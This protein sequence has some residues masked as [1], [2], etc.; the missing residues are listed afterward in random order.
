MIGYVYK[1]T[2]P[3]GRVYIGSTKNINRRKYQYSVACCKS[4]CKL[5]LS[6]VK[7]GWNNHQFEIVWEG[8]WEQMYKKEREIG[9][10]LNVLNK[11]IG[12]N[13]KLPDDNGKPMLISPEVGEKIS[14]KMKGKYVGSKNHFFGKKH[15]EEFKIK[16][17][18]ERKGKMSGENN[19]NFG[20]RWP[21]ERKQQQS[22]L[23]KSKGYIHTD[24][25]RKDQSVRLRQ[26]RLIF[27]PWSKENITDT[28]R[29]NLIKSRPRG[30]KN[31]KSKLIINI[32]TGIFYDTISDAAS[33]VGKKRDWLKYILLYSKENKTS[34]RYA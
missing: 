3:K 31:H 30:S 20:V 14:V 8:D 6:I 24:E 25:F 22:V 32:D 1:I 16:L 11:I 12:L 7:Y 4:Q 17:S 13:L 18:Q 2:N 26:R 10:M 23:V 27:N 33:S 29:M 28:H 5:Y 34:F 19:P 9:L 21:E 15:S